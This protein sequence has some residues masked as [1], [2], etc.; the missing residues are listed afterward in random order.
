LDLVEAADQRSVRYKKYAIELFGHLLQVRDALLRLAPGERDSLTAAFGSSEEGCE[1]AAKLL[2]LLTGGS[3]ADEEPEGGVLRLQRASGDS[4]AL[5]AT[6]DRLDVTEGALRAYRSIAGVM[7]TPSLSE[8]IARARRRR[9]RTQHFAL[10]LAQK[11]HTR[12]TV[13]RRTLTERDAEAAAAAAAAAHAPQEE[14]PRAREAGEESPVALLLKRLDSADAEDCDR[15]FGRFMERY[16]SDGDG[17]L[18][19]LES[20]RLIEE[21]ASYVCTEY[22]AKFSRYNMQVESQRTMITEWVRGVLDVDGDGR[23][24]RDEIANIKKAV[25]DID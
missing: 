5:L 7:D 8:A 12:A 2:V 21:V 1:R 4:N 6:S 23:I 24:T 9:Q 16:D 18:T 17:V 3:E 10:G 15:F 25:D 13:A 11:L 20:Q 22:E 19:G 14:E